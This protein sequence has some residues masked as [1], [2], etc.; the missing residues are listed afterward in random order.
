LNE[1]IKANSMNQASLFL[2]GNFLA[3][4]KVQDECPF[5]CLNGDCVNNR[6]ICKDQVG[7][8][9]QFPYKSLITFSKEKKFELKIPAKNSVILKNSLWAKNSEVIFFYKFMCNDPKIQ[10]DLGLILAKSQDPSKRIAI[11]NKEAKIKNLSC[12]KKSKFSH[13][14]FELKNSKNS[15]KFFSKISV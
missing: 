1:K 4:E 9:C 10:H 7:E 5:D 11:N 3:L 8:F 15:S 12:Q 14:K 6:C 2:K 13:G